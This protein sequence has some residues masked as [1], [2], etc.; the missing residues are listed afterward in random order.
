MCPEHTAQTMNLTITQICK[1]HPVI[2]VVTL[3]D[4]ADAVEVATALRDGGLGV[5]EVALRTD[6]APDAI[7]RIR[8][9]LPD[10][11]VGAGT[12]RG[13]QDFSRALGAGAQFGVCPG[14]TDHLLDE[15][16]RW[17]LPL[18]PGAATVSE[19]MA[20]VNAGYST[21]K[22]FPAATMGGVAALA[23]IAGP[24]PEVRFCPSGGIGADNFMSYLALDNVVSVSGSWMAPATAIRDRD[25]RLVERL[26]RDTSESAPCTTT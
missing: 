19:I 15:A 14:T 7:S 24:L 21:L 10:M 9:A 5:V 20:L 17:E 1:R 23:A 16:A 25:W 6:A 8:R 11:L 13:A 18:L 3:A 4:A 26:A 12:L 22:F 2:P